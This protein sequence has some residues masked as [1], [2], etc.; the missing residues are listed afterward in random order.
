MHEVLFGASKAYV[1]KQSTAPILSANIP[2]TTNKDLP[3]G[4]IKL[5]NEVQI[6]S[7]KSNNEA[8]RLA[9]I[10]KG[11]TLSYLSKSGEWYKVNISGRVGYVNGNELEL[12]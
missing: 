9:T 5:S 7:K 3:I 6:Y 12:E 2:E 11:E 10:H 8:F 4:K 1:K